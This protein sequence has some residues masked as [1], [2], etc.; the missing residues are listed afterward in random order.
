MSTLQFTERLGYKQKNAID[1]LT[2]GCYQTLWALRNHLEEEKKN[3]DAQDQLAF[4]LTKEWMDVDT[5]P[6]DD[7]EREE[8][9]QNWRC[10]RTKCVFHAQHCPHGST[11][12]KL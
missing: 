12:K 2:M 5:L 8:L 1:M 7:S 10:Q 4:D 3:L 9:R 6:D 11:S